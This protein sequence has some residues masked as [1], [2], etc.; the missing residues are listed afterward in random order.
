[1]ELIILREILFYIP[2]CKMKT[3]T[4]SSLP[5]DWKQIP[6]K[7]CKTLPRLPPPLL[8]PLCL[9]P[10]C[11]HVTAT[12][13]I[14]GVWS[15]GKGTSC[16]TGNTLTLLCLMSSYLSINTQ[17]KCHF[18]SESYC[19][20]LCW[21]PT[22]Q[23]FSSFFISLPIPCIYDS[24]EVYFREGV[25]LVKTLR[26]Q[27][28]RWMVLS[29]EQVYALKWL[30]ERKVFPQLEQSFF[31]LSYWTQRSCWPLFCSQLGKLR[32]NSAHKRGQSCENSREMELVPWPDYNFCFP[33]L[34]CGVL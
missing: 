26:L 22:Q 15:L 33:W 9:L 32:S 31:S 24:R 11:C 25:F 18:P 10:L 17:L 29:Q 28:S 4:G 27:C 16:F 6:Y 23:L 19:C 30:K 13:G 3:A 20:G 12:R 21:L 5:T 7:G 8:S 14:K 1:M 34:G 2:C